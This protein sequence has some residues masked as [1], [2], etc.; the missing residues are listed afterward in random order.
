MD[1]QYGVAVFLLAGLALFATAGLT[2]AFPHSVTASRRHLSPLRRERKGAS[3]H[4]FAPLHR[5]A[6][7]LSPV[8]RGRGVERSSTEWGSTLGR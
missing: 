1:R 8:D 4:K 3:P 7:F 6:P 2:S 5:L